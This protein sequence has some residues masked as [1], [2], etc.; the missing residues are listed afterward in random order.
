MRFEHLQLVQENRKRWAAKAAKT[1][2]DK[3]KGKKKASKTTKV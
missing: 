2:K 1:R 3:A